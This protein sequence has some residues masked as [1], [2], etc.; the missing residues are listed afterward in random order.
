M[1]RELQSHAGQQTAPDFTWYKPGPSIQQFHLSRAR[2][3]ALIGARGCG[4]TTAWI[5]E[6]VSHAFNFAGA[7]VYV[8]RKTQESNQDSTQESFEKLLRD[9]CGTAYV[10]N[11][12]SLFKKIEGGKYFRLPSREAVRL[13]NLFMAQSPAPNKTQQ[14]L[15]LDT[16]G[17]QYCSFIHFSG[18]PDAAT[19]ES[20]FRGYEC[21]MLVF[22]EADQLTARDLELG[23]ACL[24]WRDAFG[25]AIPDTCVIL[26]TNP[27]GKDH[28]IA[29]MEGRWIAE[30]EAAEKEGREIDPDLNSVQFWHI[31]I[32]ENAHNLEEVYVKDLKAAYAHNP[33]LY[34]KYIEGKYSDV[35]PGARV[36]WAF[37][38][39]HAFDDLPWPRGA[40]LVRGW[41]FGTYWA[42][43][44]AAYWEDGGNEYWWDLKEAYADGSDLERQCK[45]CWAITNEVFP[46]W[47]DRN[48]CSGIKD[49]CDPAGN[50]RTNKGRD[51]DVLRTYNVFPGFSMKHRSLQ[52]TLSA[53]NRLLE[54][55]DRHGRLV[56]RIDRRGCPRLYLASQ[57][58]YR[59]PDVNESGYGSGDPGKGPD[60]GNFDH[61][62]DASRYAKINCLRLLKNEMETIQKPVGR[63]AQAITPNPPKRWR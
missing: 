32:D 39:R 29:Q 26:D 12:Y 8:L 13:Y 58:G 20:R 51:L 37:S 18:V 21:S 36:L 10:D 15:W 57:G 22:V 24:R 38:E 4:K 16:V 25:Q 5:M 48:V 30:R 44:W 33:A 47:N 23:R 55:R 35:F 50:A 19:S 34:E 42:I 31:H 60:F 62:A 3:R 40:Y 61:I 28:W 43:V 63:W 6:A 2:L 41:D 53:Y 17:N 52:L 9:R 45:T 14:R 54:A 27:P 56:Y 59:Y 46:F 49:F 11:D 1:P 7:K